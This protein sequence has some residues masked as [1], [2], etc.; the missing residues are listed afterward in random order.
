MP[1]ESAI[2]NEWWDHGVRV[3]GVETW[4]E[5]LARREAAVVAEMR[6]VPLWAWS[7]VGGLTRAG[8]ALAG[9]LTRDPETLLDK[10][11]AMPAGVVTAFDLWA[12]PLSPRALRALKE[13]STRNAPVM[14]VAVAPPGTPPPPSL[15]QSLVQVRIGGP[16]SP[17]VQAWLSSTDEAL[18]Q[19]VRRQNAIQ[20]GLDV[21]AGERRGWDQVGGLSHLKRWAKR[22]QLAL[23]VDLQLPFPR[24][25]LLYGIPGT[26]KSL[27]VR[28]WAGDGG[29]PLIRLDWGGLMGRYVGDSES[30]LAGALAAAER[31]APV[32]LW[33][34]EMDKAFGF[35]G[36][37]DD[38]GVDRRLVG[39][40]LTW[41][42]EHAAPVLMLATA[43][44]V[45]GL[46]SEL[47]RP[48]RFDALF[49]VDLPDQNCRRDIMAI[50]LMNHGVAPA[51]E[52]L[53]VAEELD[54][55]SGADIAA[56]V[57]EAR[58]LGALERQAVCADLLRRSAQDVIPWARTMGEELARRRGWAKDR[59]RPA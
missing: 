42:Q 46:P 38:G 58:F 3:L 56:V 8:D 50:H 4:D 10:V 26:G 30:R 14:L 5:D 6:S 13:I 2:W 11:L 36:S 7:R 21:I 43:N 44:N 27:S 57:E 20:P 49:F 37:G 34:D 22:R 41:M 40:L 31:L 23:N 1:E 28:A 59:L 48:G 29:L 47:L 51:A 25:V 55:Y 9:A 15:A 24:G 33:V 52:M 45:A 12:E 39:M 54:D 35:P 32:V 53:S 16:R 17:R 18:V 19:H